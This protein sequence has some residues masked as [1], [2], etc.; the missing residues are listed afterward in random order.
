MVV[1]SQHFQEF[2]SVYRTISGYES[3][4]IIRKGQV[5]NFEQ[6]DI[7]GQI[8]FINSLFGIAA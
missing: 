3:I 1:A 5:E 7:L 4:N 6:D 2:W 8:N